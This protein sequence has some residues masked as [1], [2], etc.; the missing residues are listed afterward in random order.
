[1]LIRDGRCQP[2][3]LLLL[4]KMVVFRERADWGRVSVLGWWSS[5]EHKT[6]RPA[7]TTRCPASQSPS[8]PTRLS[9]GP[10]SQD[11]WRQPRAPPTAR[12]AIRN[13]ATSAPNT[14]GLAVSCFTLHSE[15]T[16][17]SC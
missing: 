4:T 12:I 6:D 2:Y 13:A 5:G 11:V 9:H 1:M 17:M 10:R 14:Q 7:S 16:A 3:V 8:V 15:R